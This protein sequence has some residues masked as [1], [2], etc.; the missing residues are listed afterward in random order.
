MLFNSIGDILELLVN[1]DW[2]TFRSTVLSSRSVFRHLASA[3]SSCSQLNG[4]TLL[5]AAVRYN[6]PLDVI[7]QM[8]EYCPTMPAARDVVNRTPLHVA[9]GS[10]ASAGLLNIIARANPEACDVQD[11]GGKT[12]LHFVCDSSAVLFEDDQ[13]V[14][15][16]NNNNRRPNHDA[17]STLLSYS[18]HASILRDDEE[19][20]PREHAI[21]SNASGRTVSLLYSCQGLARRH[22]QQQQQQLQQQRRAARAA[23][24]VDTLVI[25]VTTMSVSERSN[26]SNSNSTLRTGTV[27]S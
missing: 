5:H 1:R 11:E 27:R 13:N 2:D 12:P 14:N 16:N 6:P 9:A 26:G 18:F 20:S 23:D 7:E 21:R 24:D 22:Q 4:M 17:I 15:N 25:S 3:I 19:M 10:G 8:I